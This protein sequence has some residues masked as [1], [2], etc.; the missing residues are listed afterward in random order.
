MESNSFLAVDLGATSGRVIS[1]SIENGKLVL[2]DIHKFPNEMIAIH[3]N[4]YWNIFH[5]FRQ[6]KEGLTI[7]SRKGIKPVSIG[8]DTWGVDIAFVGEDGSLMGLPYAYRNFTT[9]ENTDSFLKQFPLDELYARTGIQT[10]DFNTVFQLYA[11]Q[12]RQSSQLKAAKHILFMPDA[13]SYLLTGQQVTEYTIAST[14]QMLNPTTKDF[15][16]KILEYIG[17]ERS[18]FPGEIVFS[19]HQVGTLTQELAQETGLGEIPVIAVAGHDT[20]SAVVSVPAV[21]HKF[22]YLSSGTWSLMGLELPEPVVND[23][24]QK[25]NITNEGGV[26]GTIRFLKNITGMWILEQCKKEWDL[27]HVYSY[28]ELVDLSHKATPFA[29]LFD[30][31]NEKFANPQSMT[32]AIAEFCR[33]TGQEIPS[34]A[35]EFVRAIFESLALRYKQ[36]FESLKT[37]ATFPID[38]LHVIGGGSR[39]EF[40]NQLTANSTGVEVLAGPAEATA[41]GNMMMQAKA[42][43]RFNNIQEIRDF[44]RTSVALNVYH[45][46]EKAVW[47]AAYLQFLKYAKPIE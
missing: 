13:I 41:I 27:E 46:Q 7:A 5:L 3:G 43:G 40:M 23:R 25:A 29:S 20:A 32:K 9:R 30:P 28:E 10:L 14:S 47:E 16:S 36:V 42:V 1:G 11:L 6:I 15:D 18:K 44:I 19:G 24:S 39:N 37:F 21:D 45:P 12:L 8:V 38:R 4:H 31:D 35:G 33:Q 26:D 22:A 34:T 17:V 2:E